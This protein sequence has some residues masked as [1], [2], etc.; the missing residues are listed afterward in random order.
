MSK[1]NKGAI[2]AAP[3][4]KQETKSNETK[5]DSKNVEDRKSVV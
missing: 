3:K 1:K 5:K 4:T 2:P